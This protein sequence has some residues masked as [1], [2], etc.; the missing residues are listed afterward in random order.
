MT[1]SVAIVGA[2]QIACAASRTF[3]LAGW[4]VTIL[5]RSPPAWPCGHERFQRYLAGHDPPP[6]VDVVLDTIAFDETDVA[7]YDPKGTDRLIVVSS[8]SGY[9]DNA[10]R[11]LDEAAQNGFPHF[12]TPVTERQPTVDPSPQTYST[13]KVRMERAAVARF[14]S[15]ATVLRPCAIHGAWSR[16]PREWWFVKRILDDRRVIPLAYQGRSRF[17]TTA[18]QLL[19]VAAE[20]AAT[21][22]MGGIF[23]IADDGAPSVTEIARAIAARMR[24]TVELSYCNT[25]SAGKGVGRTPWSIP[26]PMEVSGS[27][28]REE[29][30]L[31]AA[32]YASSIDPAI[33]WLA[34]H[35]RADWRKAFPQL[36]AYPWNLFDYAAEDRFLAGP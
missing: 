36:A 33:D 3:A 19:A 27:H 30:E 29:L 1:G 6:T 21:L 8:A 35:P 23:N 10:G 32:S 26:R 17:Q 12:E 7:R 15:R 20:R 13:R 2:G 18:V 31:P 14:G 22:R 16:H 24:A 9:C 4:R 5:A 28:A 25:S 11:T 34:A